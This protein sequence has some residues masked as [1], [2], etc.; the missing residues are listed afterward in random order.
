MVVVSLEG[1]DV[2]EEIRQPR[3]GE[4]AAHVARD[5]AVREEMLRLQKELATGGGV[6]MDGR[7][8]GTVVLP[9]GGSQG[10][11]DGDRRGKSSPAAPG[12]FGPGRN[13][14]LPRGIP[15][16]QTTRWD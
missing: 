14:H 7:D 8:I 1:E 4:L 5:P 9:H 6:V 11:F 2:T 12:A 13:D 16:R 10:V 15:I 3:V